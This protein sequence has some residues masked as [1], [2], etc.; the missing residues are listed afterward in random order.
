V[1]NDIMMP[2]RSSIALPGAYSFLVI[3]SAHNVL[4]D[5]CTSE[6]STAQLKRA[7]HQLSTGLAECEGYVFHDVVADRNALH[8]GSQLDLNESTAQPWQEFGSRL[9]VKA[10]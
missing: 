9:L 5:T 2:R 4:Q 10:E 7:S 3:G 6:C 1:A 8:R